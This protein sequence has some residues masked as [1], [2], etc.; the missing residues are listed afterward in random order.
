MVSRMPHP[1]AASAAAQRQPILLP[2]FDRQTQ[3]T[4]EFR[5]IQFGAI[6]LRRIYTNE[7]DPSIRVRLAAE[8]F[9]TREHRLQEVRYGNN[10]TLA[11][12]ACYNCRKFYGSNCFWNAIAREFSAKPETIKS[13]T[14]LF[15]KARNVYLS[16]AAPHSSSPPLTTGATYWADKWASFLNEP[17]HPT[18]TP[19]SDVFKAFDDFFKREKGRS[20][21]V[22]CILS[23]P[24]PI[25]TPPSA[26][27]D[28][29]K[30]SLSPSAP[31]WTPSA[32]RRT[33]SRSTDES[34]YGSTSGSMQAPSMAIESQDLS[35]PQQEIHETVVGANGRQ[36]QD[37]QAHW[38]SHE[39]P[40][41]GLKI[42]G[43]AQK[44]DTHTSPSRREPYFAVDQHYALEHANGELQDR[45][46]LLEK[47]KMEAATAQK[48]RDEAI[49]ALQ[50]KFASFE[51]STTADAQSPV[52]DKIVAEMTKRIDSQGEKLQ[53]MEKELARSN[54]TTQQMQATISSLQN[55]VAAQSQPPN[56]GT[57][58][59]GPPTKTAT[60]E[61]GIRDRAIPTIQKNEVSDMLLRISSLEAKCVFLNSFHKDVREM[62]ADIAAEKGK[63]PAPAP[64]PAQQLDDQDTSSRVKAVEEGIERQVQ[65][66]KAITERVGTLEEQAIVSIHARIATLESRPDPAEDISKLSSKVSTAEQNH[67]SD[68]RAIDIMLTAIQTSFEKMQSNI[69]EL[70][71]RFDELGSLPLIK[72]IVDD[73]ADAKAR[74]VRV[75]ELNL[76]ASKRLDEFEQRHDALDIQEQSSRLDEMAESVQSIK[77]SLLTLA[78]SHDVETL[79]AE[80]NALSEKQ[81]TA[82]QQKV[83]DENV[84]SALKSAIDDQSTRMTSLDQACEKFAAETR[85]KFEQHS[86]T[87][88][89]S[90]Q[91]SRLDNVSAAV[92]AMCQ[93]VGIIENGFRAMRDVMTSRRR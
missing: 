45:V 12:K 53:E 50:A 48:D 46:D 61:S 82:S 31:Q 34:F 69:N 60:I 55:L 38:T 92:D 75:G 42:R 78:D 26:P 62:K 41:V 23:K 49:R 80:F 54:Q 86:R 43:Q 93:R 70:S 13:V 73:V 76:D 2:G 59:Q 35:H 89:S 17:Q 85:T 74:L 39:K 30:R 44:L 87:I 29:R 88:E 52:S 91:D 72:T 14:D 19:A 11:L 8:D 5:T 57:L 65:T 15:I 68:I 33:V 25:D 40:Y 83:D 36:G 79:R 32:K 16:T 84:S 67:T 7:Q 71:K 47:E 90:A 64:R 77:T 56:Q 63:P 1:D 28:P 22:A 58:T 27:R 9:Y 24:A 21:D 51:R 3:L 6:W 66:A 18:P 37:D 10:I 81:N 4:L 20:G